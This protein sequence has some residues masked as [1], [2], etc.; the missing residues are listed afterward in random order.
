[1]YFL[2]DPFSLL[3]L[4]GIFAVVVLIGLVALLMI[5]IMRQRN[6]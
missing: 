4:A 2:A 5:K 6:R 1:M 3:V